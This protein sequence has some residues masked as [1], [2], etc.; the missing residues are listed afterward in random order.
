MYVCDNNTAARRRDNKNGKKKN[1]FSRIII[2]RNGC[3]TVY[4]NYFTPKYFLLSIWYT[5]RQLITP[6]LLHGCFF[7]NVTTIKVRITIIII[8]V[9]TSFPD[10]FAKHGR[11]FLWYFYFLLYRATKHNNSRNAFDLV[12]YVTYSNKQ[13]VKLYYNNTYYYGL[14]ELCLL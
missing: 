10:R 2:I 8:I 14:W 4:N 7:F 1:I 5:V 12:V 9:V 11:L 13:S 3:P 6:W